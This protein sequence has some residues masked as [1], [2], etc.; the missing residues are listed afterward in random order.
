MTT[1]TFS[2]RF[3]IQ[4]IFCEIL[5]SLLLWTARCR[6]QLSVSLTLDMRRAGNRKWSLPNLQ[7]TCNEKEYRCC[8]NL[9]NLGVIAYYSIVLNDKPE[10]TKLYHGRPII[11]MVLQAF[12]HGV[13]SPV[14]P[15]TSEWEAIPRFCT[16][17]LEIFK[18]ICP[19]LSNTDKI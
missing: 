19:L 12:L 10:S 13:I 2:W 15:I 9:G 18:A 14:S 7:G 17:I 8:S 6:E 5:F 1:C 3:K 4:H 11:C 16:N